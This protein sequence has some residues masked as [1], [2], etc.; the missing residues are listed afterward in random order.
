MSENATQVQYQ[1]EI[2]RDDQRV[3]DIGLIRGAHQQVQD[4]G[5]TQIECEKQR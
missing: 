3:E 4:C 5:Q 1:R 2:E